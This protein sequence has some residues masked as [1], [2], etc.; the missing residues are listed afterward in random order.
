MQ[1][2]G[3]SPGLGISKTL[4]EIQSLLRQPHA[5]HRVSS[6][7]SSSKNLYKMQRVVAMSQSLTG[8]E[9]GKWMEIK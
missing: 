2:D 4:M 9:A 1:P 8:E 5:S 7:S 3:I 6:H